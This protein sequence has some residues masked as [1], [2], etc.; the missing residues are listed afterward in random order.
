MSEQKSPA[1][2]VS[3]YALRYLPHGEY[4]HYVD[5]RNQ[6]TAALCDMSAYTFDEWRGDGTNYQRAALQDK[7]LCSRCARLKKAADARLGI[8]A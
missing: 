2:K 7:I 4:A 8:V 6:A 1:V 5:V 3:P